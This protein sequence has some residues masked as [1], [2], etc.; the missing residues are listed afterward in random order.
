MSLVHQVQQSARRCDQDMHA[1]TQST[2]LAVLV[3]AAVNERVPDFQMLAVGLET[4]AD[5][6]RQFSRR[7]E[8]QCVGAFGIGPFVLLRQ[9]IQNRQRERGRFA[10]SGLST[11]EDVLSLECGGDSLCL[12]RRRCFVVFARDRALDFGDELQLIKSPSKDFLLE[13]WFEPGPQ[14]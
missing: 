4:V 5:L 13:K 3:D 12:N 1:L 9:F 6:D 7:C 10:G 14:S 11:S 2:H 8:D